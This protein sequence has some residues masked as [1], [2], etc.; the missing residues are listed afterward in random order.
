MNKFKQ[1][2]VKYGI[3]KDQ[4]YENVIK[5]ICDQ[6]HMFKSGHFLLR[7]DNERDNDGKVNVEI[8]M[9]M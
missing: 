3:E 1:L 5:F 6:I 7:F 8:R 4:L 2:V 9:S